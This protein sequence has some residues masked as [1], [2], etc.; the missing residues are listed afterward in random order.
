[1]EGREAHIGDF[2]FAEDKALIGDIVQRLGH[3]CGRQ[4]GC[5]RA[6]RQRKAQSSGAQSRHSGGFG[7]TLPL[8]R[9]FHPWH[10]RILHELSELFSGSSKQI[11]RCTHAACKRD[12]FTKSL[13]HIH[14]LF[15]LINVSLDQEY[16]QYAL[17]RCLLR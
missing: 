4:R 14:L 15:M 2:L 6:P 7:H 5:G 11:L 1:V 17:Q 3:I 8:R 10:R 9:L 13:M 16:D 12:T